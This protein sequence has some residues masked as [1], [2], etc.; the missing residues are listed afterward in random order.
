MIQNVMNGFFSDL[1]S[2]FFRSTDVNDLV[3]PANRDTS[4]FPIVSRFVIFVVIL[5]LCRFHCF[6]N[7]IV[8]KV[9][10]ATWFFLLCVCSWLL[11]GFVVVFFISSSPSDESYYYRISA[12]SSP[13]SSSSASFDS[14]NV[15][16]GFHAAFASLSPH[17][18]SREY[19]LS[20]SGPPSHD[21]LVG[22]YANQENGDDG[23]DAY[24]GGGVYV[25]FKDDPSLRLA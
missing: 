13:S 11:L 24:D 10:Y 15:E 21:R 25:Q 16:D 22:E 23:M 4:T 7:N 12:V 6:S 1:I 20:V 9:W 8:V 18:L 3:G 14:S 19:E 2:N 17:S 5:L